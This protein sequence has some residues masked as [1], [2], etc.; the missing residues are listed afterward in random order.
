MDPFRTIIIQIDSQAM[1]CPARAHHCDREAGGA[2]KVLNSVDG[3]RLHA[4]Q[5]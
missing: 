4:I 1:V 2:N 3:Q 5:I